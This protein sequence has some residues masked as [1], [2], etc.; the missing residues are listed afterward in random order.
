MSCGTS[1]LIFSFKFLLKFFFSF[2]I[3]SPLGDLP[4]PR[5]LG[6][7]RSVPC[8]LLLA[9]ARASFFRSCTD[10]CRAAA[11][12][13]PSRRAPTLRGIVLWHQMARIL[14]DCQHNSLRFF[15]G[16]RISVLVVLSPLPSVGSIS[17]VGR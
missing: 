16:A 2:G 1:F 7:R 8:G 13:R 10:I 6:S 9:S 15:A 4:S 12:L 11:G 14:R 17:T 3:F 5:P